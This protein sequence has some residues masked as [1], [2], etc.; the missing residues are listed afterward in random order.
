M[1]ELR[2]LRDTIEA[3]VAYLEHGFCEVSQRRAMLLRELDSL[4][5]E[6]A[7][8]EGALAELRLILAQWGG[9]GRPMPAFPTSPS[10]AAVYELT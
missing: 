9:G 7:R 5:K 10:P 6:L 2:D 3:R 4:E 8:I 1:A